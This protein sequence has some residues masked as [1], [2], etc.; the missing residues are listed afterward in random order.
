[1]ST[2]R[3]DEHPPAQR[4]YDRGYDDYGPPNRGPDRYDD[5]GRGPPDRYDDRG[6]GPPDRYD[7]RGRAPPDRYDDRGRA[8][9]DR[10]PDRYDRGGRGPPDRGPD[11]Y[12]DYD[13]GRTP[14]N[15]YGNYDRYDDRRRGPPDRCRDYDDDY[16]V[17][18]GVGRG[19]YDDY[20][21]RR[22]DRRDNDYGRRQQEDT[23]VLDRDTG[24][25]KLYVGGIKPETSSEVLRELMT[26]HG[27]VY[28]CIVMSGGFGFCTY[29]NEAAT[30]KAMN[31]KTMVLDGQAVTV[32]KAKPKKGHGRRKEEFDS[33]PLRSSRPHMLTSQR[34]SQRPKNFYGDQPK[35]YVGGVGKST[36][37]DVFTKKMSE[38]GEVLDAIVMPGGFGFCTY[39][40]TAGTDA[41][42]TASIVFNVEGKECTLVAQVAKPPARKY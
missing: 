28:D 21:D 18:R 30:Q 5:R 24:Q 10:G 20:D 17:G 25:E 35:L 36:P 23:R 26:Q 39:V 29:K 3:Y 8:P 40:D 6:R 2:H 19:R 32:Q 42:L 9:P 15:R 13:R 31:C 4:G 14:P 11:R 38:L 37:T 33:R 27:E 7:D 34:D 41:A 16:G 1:M 22:D 12:D